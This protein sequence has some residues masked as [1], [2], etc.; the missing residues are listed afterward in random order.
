MKERH[1]AGAREIIQRIR[2]TAASYTPE[3]NFNPEDPDI[4]SALALVYTD[5]LEGT[6]QGMERLGYKNQLAFFG[7][8]G[9]EQKPAVPARGYAV[10]SVM[11]GASAGT[12]VE[13]NTLMA[14]DLDTEEGGSAQ[15]ETLEDVHVVPAKPTCLYMT[16]GEKDVIY[17]ISENISQEEALLLFRE[18]G[19]NL[20]KHEL[21]L[22]HDEILEICQEAY[23][24][25]GL[26][27]RES[28]SAEKDF[29]EALTD[30]SAARFTYWTEEGWREFDS[31]SL[32]GERILLHKKSFSAAAARMELDGRQ[33]FALRCEAFDT[34]RLG[35]LS[36]ENISLQGHGERLTPQ[37]VYGAGTQCSLKEYFPFGERLNLFEEVYF[38]S[39]EILG[40]RGAKITLSFSMDFVQIPLETSGTPGEVEWKWIMKRSD[41][42]PDP[43]YDVAIEQVIWEYYNGSGW[44]RLFDGGEHEDAF[45]PH[46]GVIGR[47]KTISFECPRDIRPVLVESCETCYIRA[48]ILKIS[49]LYKLKGK[50]I[51]PVLGNTTFSYAYPESGRR[52]QGIVMENNLERSSLWGAQLEA[53]GEGLHPFVGVEERQKALY[54]GFDRAPVGAPVRMLLELEDMIPG[55]E[56][57][58][59]WEY[60]GA[61]GFKE[62]NLADGTRN[63]TRTGLVT[64]VGASDFRLERRFGQ[65]LYW[66]R[67]R[68]ESGLYAEGST[69]ARYPVLR[70]LWMNAV[71]IRHMDREETEFF[72]LDYFEDTGLF[73]LMRGNISEIW[74]DVL[75]GAQAE[76]RW[77]PWQET[78]D[79]ENEPG[80][81][82]VYQVDRIRGTIQFGNGTHGRVPPLGRFEGIRV[83]YKCAGGRRA[84]ASAGKVNRLNQTVGYVTGVRNPEGLS[85]GLD[86]EEIGETLRRSGARLRHGER[87]ITVRDYE[88]LAREAS[89]AIQK[90]RCFGGRNARG[91]REA[92]AVTLIVLPQEYRSDKSLF[93]TVQE[94]IRGYLEPRMDPVILER[95][96]FAVIQP[97]FVEI[98]VRAELGVK[99][100]QDIFQVRRE[101]Q[102]RLRLFLDPVQG[103]FDGR[104]WNIGELP[105]VMQIQNALKEIPEVMWI[106]ELYLITYVSGERGR[107]EIDPDKIRQNPYVLPLSGAHQIEVTVKQTAGTRQGKRDK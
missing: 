89:R 7:S 40:K 59:S 17:R 27:V 72:T 2:E 11:E 67:L 100:F 96:Q 6:L 35:G 61:K 77:V 21:I 104:G 24:E 65:E 74:V 63:L 62:M 15:Y 99:S 52:P 105:G 51:V 13:A 93:Y 5:M 84:N 76:A 53:L 95:E 36:V 19:E 33:T 102:E 18:K 31:V 48:R 1:P 68:D 42:R 47:Q 82:R 45:S 29:L 71:E 106:Q 56:G 88:E 58:I 75:E 54:L 94:E 55:R 4:G 57:S 49:N 78:K 25:L 66:I 39:Q 23:L 41:F 60:L 69:E 22:S 9:A 101:A 8:L 20:Q 64:F 16:D 14:A 103:H 32:L 92:G 98:E 80:D 12:E 44:N 70:R 50:Y 83:H 43:E 107:Q 10:F 85:G 3:W 26:Y 86:V 79:L 97:R 46:G 37:I 38:G 30:S 34:K 73:N 28:Q 90:V 87:A 81:A 91:E